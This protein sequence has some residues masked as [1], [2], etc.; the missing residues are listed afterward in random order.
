MGIQLKLALVS[1]SVKQSQ[2]QCHAG[3]KR[4]NS[5]ITPEEKMLWC[6]SAVKCC[7][8]LLVYSFFMGF[9]SY[10]VYDFHHSSSKYTC[11]R[12]DFLVFHTL[13]FYVVFF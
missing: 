12:A 3:L 5:H 4:E 13:D 8:V 9:A 2:I 7:K 6:R 11:P 10:A 1:A